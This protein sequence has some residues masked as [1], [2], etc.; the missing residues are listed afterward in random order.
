[1]KIFLSHPHEHRRVADALCVALRQEG[2]QPTLDVELL[3][4]GDAFHAPL[5]KA[6]EGSDLFV[7][8]LSP[9]SLEE[10]SYA[11]T[12]L[13]FAR[14]RWPDPTDR[15]LPVR[16]A[17]IDFDR[18]PPYLA[19]VTVLQPQGDLVAAT[20]ARIS[21]IAARRRRRRRRLAVAAVVALAV[22]ALSAWFVIG[23]SGGG[24]AAPCLVDAT[25]GDDDAGRRVTTLEVG[26]AD[27]LRAF[28]IV[29]G[30]ANLAVPRLTPPDAPWI[31]VART[32]GGQPLA[33][34]ESRGCPSEPRAMQDD[35]TGL[36]IELAPRR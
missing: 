15:V 4:A 27:D 20:V 23:R 7:Y 30:V 36:R 10:G 5:R 2:H 18:V 14:K 33:R 8:L 22:A 26:V 24:P 29:G 34:F 16:V 25:V 28:V 32:A 19:S 9:A 11:L 6:I 35:A 21:E 12:E 17:E 1:M 31:I 13:D 3:A